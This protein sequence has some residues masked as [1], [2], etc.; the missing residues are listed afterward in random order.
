MFTTENIFR[1]KNES[2][3]LIHKKPHKNLWIEAPTTKSARPLDK[4]TF[5][6]VSKEYQL[7]PLEHFLVANT[8]LKQQINKVLE[9]EDFLGQKSSR[10]KELQKI[11]WFNQKQVTYLIHGET[12]YGTGEDAMNEVFDHQE[13]CPQ[14]K[15]NSNICKI[16]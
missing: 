5:V 9:E 15:Y 10:Y 7:P 2:V 8:W 16:Y 3:E 1:K 14:C 6:N 11:L 4:V 12:K 13:Q